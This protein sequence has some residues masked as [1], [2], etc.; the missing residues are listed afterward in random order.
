MARRRGGLFNDGYAPMSPSPT[1]TLFQG[2]G[3]GLTWVDDTPSSRAWTRKT[4]DQC[5][6]PLGRGHLHGPLRIR[7]AGVGNDSVYTHTQGLAR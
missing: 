3:G 4:G 2:F 1:G 5:P 7:I 6:R